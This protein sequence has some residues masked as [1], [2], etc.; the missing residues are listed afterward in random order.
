ME[1]EDLMLEEVPMQ[2]GGAKKKPAVTPSKARVKVGKAT[3]IVY[4]GPRGGKY[5][6]KDGKLVPLNNKK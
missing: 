6:K 4:E 1:S 5:V 3:R 2:D